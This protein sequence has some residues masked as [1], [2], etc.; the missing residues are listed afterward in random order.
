MEGRGEKTKGN[1]RSKMWRGVRRG[2]EKGD[3][4]KGR[5]CEKKKSKE[6][7]GGSNEGGKASEAKGRVEEERRKNGR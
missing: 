7:R 6:E 2:W 1:R 5:G 4:K 3:G